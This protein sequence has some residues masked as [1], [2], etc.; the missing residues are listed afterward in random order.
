MRKTA[1]SHR[2]HARIPDRAKLEAWAEKNAYRVAIIIALAK[3]RA[4]LGEIAKA[5]GVRSPDRARWLLLR[6]TQLRGK[7]ALR[8]E[9]PLYTIAEICTATGMC[10]RVV[11]KLCTDGVVASRFRG[12]RERLIGLVGLRTLF[13]YKRSQQIQSRSCCI[14]HKRF[15]SLRR[16]T[17]S[18]PCRRKL[19][20]KRGANPKRLG[21]FA[22]AILRNIGR[23]K[24]NRR[25]EQWLPYSQAARLAGIPAQ[26]LSWLRIS[27]VIHSRR[28]NRMT[29]FGHRAYEYSAA[30]MLIIRRVIEIQS[31]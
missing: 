1:E 6:I 4:T 10:R 19:A 23:R 14:C 29:V 8:P 11:N 30:E 20:I 28:N 13:A 24:R 3:E 21:G 7:E 22:R 26:K 31:Q 27:R 9:T 15:D 17:C 16:A 18:G 2:R 25:P 5:I 12:R